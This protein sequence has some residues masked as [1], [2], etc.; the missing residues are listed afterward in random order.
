MS[1]RQID[2]MQHLTANTHTCNQ[3]SS[4]AMTKANS[5]SREDGS[6]GEQYHPNYPPI[7]SEPPLVSKMMAENLSEIEQDD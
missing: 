4:L 1:D 2:Q 5:Q 3:H 7:S 6:N